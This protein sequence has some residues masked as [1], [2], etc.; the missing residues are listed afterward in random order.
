MKVDRKWAILITLIT[1]LVLVAACGGNKADP[2]VT[3]PPAET[4]VSTPPADIEP[5]PTPGAASDPVEEPPSMSIRDAQELFEGQGLI[6]DVFFSLDQ[7]DLGTNARNRLAKNA[8]FMKSEKGQDF[9]FTVEGH[10]DERGTNEY[11]IALGQ[12]RGSGA[13]D[14][15]VSLGIDRGRF[16]VVSFG[17]ERPFC[18]TSSDACWQKNRRARFVITGGNG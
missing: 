15:L 5:T 18:T 11:N 6:G 14:Y 13:L 2:V 3:P 9:T 4:M 10:C 12:R 7:Y 16:R 17:E 8:E 1:C